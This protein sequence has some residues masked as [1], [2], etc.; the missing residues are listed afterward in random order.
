MLGQIPKN[1]TKRFT[2]AHGREE[3][4]RGEEGIVMKNMEG[5]K[6]ADL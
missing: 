6:F 2:G 1:E 4:Q 3:G 5:A